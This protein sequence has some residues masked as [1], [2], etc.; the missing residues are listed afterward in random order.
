MVPPVNPVKPIVIISFSLAV[1]KALTMFAEFP[2]VESPINTS[3]LF[4]IPSTSLA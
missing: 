3:P 2:E 4:P 1:S